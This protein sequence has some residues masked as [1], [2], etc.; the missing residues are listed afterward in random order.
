M[1][2]A[3]PA[4]KPLVLPPGAGRRYPMGRIEAVF[5][6]DGPESANR[7]AISEWWLEPRTTGPAPTRMPRT[8]SSTSWR[9]R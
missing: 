1:T 9:E 3:A 7:Y 5:K 2:G 6:A 8:M 4:R